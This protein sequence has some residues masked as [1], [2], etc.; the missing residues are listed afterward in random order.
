[1]PKV[2][3]IIPIYGV[4][5]YIARCAH[6]LFNQT[7]YDIEYIF[8]DDCTKDNSLD[9]LKNVIS[10][11]PE[12][13]KNIQIVHH[14]FNKGLPAARKTGLE[15]AK[16]NFVIH[17]DSDDWVVENAFELMYNEAINQNADIVVSDYYRIDSKKTIVSSGFETTENICFIN[18][19]L[20]LR[21]ACS[22]WNKLVKRS[23]YSYEID[24]PQFGMAEDLALMVQLCYHAKKICGIHVPLYYYYHNTE[25]ISRQKTDVI[26][27]KQC[28]EAC[29]NVR[30][31]DYFFKRTDYYRLYRNA[32][33]HQKLIQ[34]DR[35]FSLS[36]NKEIYFKWHTTF[37]EINCSLFFNPCN[38]F[39]EKLRYLLGRLNLYK[40]LLLSTK[41]AK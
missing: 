26:I 19:M 40:F 23:L 2:S 36:S 9:I 13:E 22:V 37:K 15:Y 20:M 35:L 25:S 10:I 12:R 16:G 30:L 6:S 1:M 28:N 27:L 3:V 34:R 24:Y 32:I 21:Y 14:D 4:E 18:D 8:V 38:S 29:S 5:K 39:R 41:I 31:I 33:D 17:C 7:L 11:Y